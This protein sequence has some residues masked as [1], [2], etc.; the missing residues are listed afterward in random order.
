MTELTSGK[1]FHFTF[2]VDRS[3]SM[4][5][6]GIAD[7]KDALEIFIRSLPVGCT[8]SIISFGSRHRWM[9]CIE[10]TKEKSDGAR[11]RKKSKSKKSSKRSNK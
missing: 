9:R 5:G 2:I 10:E 4:G 6:S 11:R 1:D 7:A 8:F 3:G